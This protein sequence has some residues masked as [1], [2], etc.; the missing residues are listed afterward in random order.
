[1]ERVE[2]EVLEGE[3]IYKVDGK[4]TMRVEREDVRKLNFV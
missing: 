2:K 1:M 3:A 4:G